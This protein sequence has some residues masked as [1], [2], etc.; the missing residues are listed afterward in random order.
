MSGARSPSARSLAVLRRLAAAPPPSPGA[1]PEERC[2]LCGAPV[3]AEHRHLVDLESRSLVC[4]CR[5]CWLLF[6]EGAEQ[7]FRAVPERYL[8]LPPLAAQQWDALEVP[9]GLCFL[10]A[11]SVLGRMVAIYPGPAGA[12]E[13]ELPLGAWQEIVAAVPELAE[14][15]P[16][17]EALLVSADGR[18]PAR[19][20]LVP[21]DRCYELVGRLRRVWRGFDGGAEARAEIDG[22]LADVTARSRP[23]RRAAP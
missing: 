20:S 22:L 5:P 18:S 12:T 9:V 2:E 6:P 14:L 11:S 17:V 13:S 8:S 3:A 16:D 10:F 21:V 1:G 4:A 23:V 15:R 19:C 7:R